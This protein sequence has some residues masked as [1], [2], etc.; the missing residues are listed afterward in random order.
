M[1]S[2]VL[3][4]GKCVD[5]KAPDKGKIGLSYLDLILQSVARI[6]GV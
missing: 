3:T 5:V 6:F 2:V 1:H 4:L